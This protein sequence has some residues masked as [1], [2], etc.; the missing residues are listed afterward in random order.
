MA[1][2]RLSFPFQ[3]RAKRRERKTEFV[4]SVPLSLDC[5]SLFTLPSFLSS[6]F[7]QVEREQMVALSLVISPE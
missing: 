3:L 2:I 4:I 1:G 6:V 7:E 5:E